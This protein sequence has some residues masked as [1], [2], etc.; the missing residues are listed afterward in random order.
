MTDRVLMVALLTLSCVACGGEED[1][2][3]GCG[4]RRVDDAMVQTYCGEARVSVQVED[5]T[6]EWDDAEC[7]LEPDVVA[8]GAGTVGREST[9]DGF[10]LQV[11]ASG[12]GEDLTARRD[13]TYEVVAISFT[14]DAEAY[15]VVAAPAGHDPP[16]V[17]VSDGR[18]RGTFTGP[19]VVG[20]EQVRT[21]RVSGSF[22]CPG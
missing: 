4:R 20:A 2:D 1:G 3:T 10:L 7:R 18:R 9:E 15:T 16:Q 14:V 11:G 17:T 13:G 12:A 8:V 21:V 22:E 5:T 6:H 19:A